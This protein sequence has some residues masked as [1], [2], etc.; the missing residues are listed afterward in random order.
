MKRRL[1]IVPARGGSKRILNKNIRQFCGQPMIAHILNTAQSSGLFDIIHVSTDS[2]EIRVVVEQLGFAVDFM[3]PSNLADD[4]TP[5][6]P[7]MKYVADIFAEQGELFDEVWLLMAC[8]PLI[9]AEDLQQA[10]ALF[11]RSGSNTCVLGVAEY[12]VPVEWAFRRLPDGVM[13]PLQP[14]MFAT[15]SQDLEKKYFDAG[16]FAAF[17]TAKVRSSEGAGSDDGFIGHIIS[18]S[19]AIDIDDEADWIHAELM[20]QISKKLGLSLK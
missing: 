18:K 3:R 8:S 10:A 12:Q 14:G 7:V 6:M 13:S 15:R 1:A 9:E 16:V 4:H 20:Y 5:I 17:P 11:D 2:D 19:K